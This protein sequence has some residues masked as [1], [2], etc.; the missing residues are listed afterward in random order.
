[1]P[2]LPPEVAAAVA[3]AGPDPVASETDPQTQLLH[4]VLQRGGR[5]NGQRL[6]SYRAD[7]RHKCWLLQVYGTPRGLFVRLR[8]RGGLLVVPLG[9]AGEYPAECEHYRRTFTLAQIEAN[10]TPSTPPG[11]SPG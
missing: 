10:L 4:D 8:R 7:C 9:Q 11:Q 3:A 5:L 1:M 2:K 6:L